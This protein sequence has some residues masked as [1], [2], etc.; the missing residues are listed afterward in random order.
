MVWLCWRNGRTA[1]RGG[2]SRR[3]YWLITL[4]LLFGGEIAGVIVGSL[5]IGGLQTPIW[6]L[7]GFTWEGLI[8]GGAASYLL[9]NRAA[10]TP[11]LVFGAPWDPTHWSPEEALDVT[12]APDSKEPVVGS[13]PGRRLILVDEWAGDRAHI[14]TADGLQGWVDGA[15]LITFRSERGDVWESPAEPDGSQTED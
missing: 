11:V 9:A 10:R 1:R 14:G 8:L 4:G 2:H 15:G 6:V 3:R 7:Y 13:I 12:D 5:W